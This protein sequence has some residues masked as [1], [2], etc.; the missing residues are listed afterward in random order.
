M[1]LFGIFVFSFYFSQWKVNQISNREPVYKRPNRIEDRINEE[2]RLAAEK[3]AQFRKEKGLNKDSES[4]MPTEIYRQEI[5]HASRN[6][7]KIE[8]IEA[9]IE[10]IE[11]ETTKDMERFDTQSIKSDSINST[12]TENN[13][14]K[15]EQTEEITLDVEVVADENQSEIDKFEELANQVELKHS[16]MISNSGSH[17]FS[18]ELDLLSSIMINGIRGTETQK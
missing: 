8:Q 17:T 4:S 10:K 14:V 16:D 5:E 18:G 13:E 2:I 11:L 7:Q 6:L 9:E 1:R 3:E 15:I 12:H